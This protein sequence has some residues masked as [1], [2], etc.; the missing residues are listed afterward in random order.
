MD[1]V[2]GYSNNGLIVIQNVFTKLIK[3]LE[4]RDFRNNTVELLNV[5]MTFDPSESFIDYGPVRMT[6]RK[7][8]EQELNWYLS[9]DKNIKG[10]PGIETNPIWKNCATEQGYV[11][12]NYGNIVFSKDEHNMSQYDY[13][14]KK[15]KE[16]KCTRQAVMIYT[17]P[18]LHVESEDN[19]HA[20]HD[21][22][23]TTHVQVFITNDNE[24]EYIVN[25][26][27]NDAIYG[28]QNDY[29]WHKYVY[30]KLLNDLNVKIGHIYWNAGSMHV[31]ERHYDLLKEIMNNL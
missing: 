28:L 15:L 7:Y 9:M 8:I 23:C 6:N 31:Y 14:L 30:D 27:S 22:T 25:M 5:H 17:R 1:N 13:C 16:D 2:N 4:T 3:K 29:C 24:L 19:V 10:H 20:K 12:S 18:Q 26:R 11:N 21:F